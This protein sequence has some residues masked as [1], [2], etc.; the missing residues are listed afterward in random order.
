MTTPRDLDRLAKAVK[1]RRLELGLAR[2]AGAQSAGISK[3]TWKKV[4]EGQPVRD[5]SYAKI[6]GVLGWA[7]GSCELIMQGGEPIPVESARTADGVDISVIPIQP[8]DLAS[9]VTQAVQTASIATIGHLT[10]D[11]I[12]K[13][14]EQVVEN[15]RARGVI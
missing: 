5:M 12:K 7:T 4:E 8:R 6:D 3:D 13:L 2:L 11:E 9:E 10:A 14:S 1:R 15:L